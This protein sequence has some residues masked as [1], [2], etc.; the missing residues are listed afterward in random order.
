MPF[1]KVRGPADKPHTS[2]MT[3]AGRTIA[4]AI[5]E[6]G[7][8]LLHHAVSSGCATPTGGWIPAGRSYWA[9]KGREW[10]PDEVVP[11]DGP[12]NRPPVAFWTQGELY[13]VSVMRRTGMLEAAPGQ[14]ETPA[15]ATSPNPNGG[16]PVRLRNRNRHRWP[17][18]LKLSAKAEEWCKEHH[19]RA[20]KAMRR[21]A[22]RERQSIVFGNDL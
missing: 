12:A 22:W 4:L 1:K 3:K 18:V 13:A 17:P 10:R 16:K 11:A 5:W 8:H 2:I 6:S 9:A 20:E 19:R 15:P 21:K 7:D 14:W